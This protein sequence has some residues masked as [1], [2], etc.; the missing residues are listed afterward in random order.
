M[1]AVHAVLAAPS[2][3]GPDCCLQLYSCICF[4]QTCSFSLH[5]MLCLLTGVVWITWII[6][7]FLSVWILPAPIHCRGSFSE[8]VMLN[9]SKSLAN[10]FNLKVNYSFK[11]AVCNICK[12]WQNSKFQLSVIVQA[13]AYLANKA[14]SDFDL[15]P[16]ITHCTFNA[17]NKLIVLAVVTSPFCHLKHKCE[18]LNFVSL[19]ITSAWA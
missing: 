7:M 17:Q 13:K 6:V 11:V 15:W 16:E 10:M 14:Y 1:L 19:Q 4:L 12:T 3:L 2:M 5:N 8:Q 18:S 9:F